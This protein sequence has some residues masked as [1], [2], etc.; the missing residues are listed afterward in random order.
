MK[1]KVWKFEAKY[2]TGAQTSDAE[3]AP[4]KVRRFPL[5]DQRHLRWISARLPRTVK[6]RGQNG[7]SGWGC[8]CFST[9]DERNVKE[10]VRDDLCVHRPLMTLQLPAS[11]SL[12]SKTLKKKHFLLSPIVIS[13]RIVFMYWKKGN[14]SSTFHYSLIRS[15]ANIIRYE[16]K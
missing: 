8:D 14:R 2:E 12:S 5:K 6:Q 1:T 10:N 3:S 15:L 13:P 11:F 4:N 7:D 16:R 9:S